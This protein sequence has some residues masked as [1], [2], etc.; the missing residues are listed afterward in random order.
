VNRSSVS[1]HP[2]FRR[3]TTFVPIAR[4]VLVSVLILCYPTTGHAIPL[5]EYHRRIEQAINALDSLTQSD[6]G[7]TAS[8]RA[9]R[10]NSTINAVRTAVPRSEKVEWNETSFDADN[11]W[12]DETLGEF[13]RLNDW[14][15]NRAEVL[16][17]IIE[18]LQAIDARLQEI[19][20]AVGPPAATKSEAKQ[21]LSDILQR[22]EY[23]KT[24]NEG[25]AL[26]HLWQR[27]LKWLENLFPESKPLSPGRASAVSRFAQVFVV[28]LALAVISYAVRVFAPR[29]WRGRKT[30]KRAKPEARVVL[31]ERLEPDQSASDL[32]S[33]AEA[34]AR[35]GD[36][37]A[38]IR[39]AYIALLVELSDR[40][41]VSLAQYKTNRDY[42]RSVRD[43][44]PLYR[45]MKKLTDSFEQHW[46]GLAQAN[47]TDWMAF[48]AGYR[49]A[50]IST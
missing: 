44:E 49:E 17:R 7:E 21:R 48:Q 50:L 35:A 14:D 43:V 26:P 11:A 6:E 22:P 32:L 12:L 8:D 4:L 9:S 27:F 10:M 19:R 20:K 39:K 15:P 36:L 16:A 41:I 42:L 31:G 28:L 45:N 37:R 5:A 1:N 23:A 38:A 29:L 33:E 25:S 2:E 40:K 47:E 13:E 3:K 24:V 34:L 46:Y 18:R 30:R